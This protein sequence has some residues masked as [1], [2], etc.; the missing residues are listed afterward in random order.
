M[1]MTVRP[2][3]ITTHIGLD[4]PLALIVECRRR[5]IEDQDR[6]V[7]C[8]RPGN[9]DALPLSA[10]K[11]GASLLNHRVVALWQLRD[12]LVGASEARDGRSTCCARGADLD[13]REGGML[14]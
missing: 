4:Y 2:L 5:F 13:A 14:S 12:E 9:G 1:M 8:E 3:T 10:G 6:W 7:G 11:V